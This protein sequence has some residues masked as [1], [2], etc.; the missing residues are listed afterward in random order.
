[1]DTKPLA[2]RLARYHG[3]RDPVRIARALDY[4]YVDNR[5]PGYE[6]RWVC[7]HELGHSLLHQGLN[8]DIS[9]HPYQYG[10]QPVRT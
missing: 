2:T 6:R 4:I 10:H 8:K 5:L 7:A 9:G 3:T 1:M